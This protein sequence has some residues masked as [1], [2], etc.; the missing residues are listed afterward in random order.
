MMARLGKPITRFY[1][2][3]ISALISCLPQR[4]SSYVTDLGSNVELVIAHQGN[5]IFIQTTRGKILDSKSLTQDVEIDMAMLPAEKTDVRAGS[6]NTFIDANKEVLGTDPPLLQQDDNLDITLNGQN[7]EVDI[8][9]LDLSVSMEAEDGDRQ[10]CD[11]DLSG[12]SNS[13]NVIP[14]TINRD[15]NTVR[16]TE[17]EDPTSRLVDID[18]DNGDDTIIVHK[19]QGKLLQFGSTEA[20]APDHTVLFASVGGKIQQVGADDFDSE[21]DD[22]VSA[23]ITPAPAEQP[24]GSNAM[25]YGIVAKM[26]DQYQGNRKCLYIIPERDLFMVKLSYPLEVMENLDGVLRFDLEKHIP[27]SVDGVRYFYALN[28]DSLEN[29]VDVD[30]AVIKSNDFDRLNQVLGRFANRDLLCTTERFYRK[31]GNRINFLDASAA[32]TNYSFLRLSNIHQAFNYAL[33]LVLIALP[34]YLFHQGI[35]NIGT[36]SDSEMRR[37]RDIVTSINTINDESR[38]GS[39]LSAQIGK[40]PKIVSLLATLSDSI[41]DGA[42][43]DR[44]SYK[45]GEISIR[46]EADS[47]TA[48]SDELS[49]T[50]L[51]ENIKFVSSIRKNPKSGQETFELLMRLKPDA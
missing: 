25:A 30:I 20:Q 9:L 45:D 2:W 40:A 26:L 18:R 51:F 4:Y 49:R 42:W 8:N 47:A 24:G 28:V 13:Q 1:R 43:L 14:L 19:D 5:S 22:A 29:R 37:V 12:S 38:F 11:I 34:F 33:L 21:D 16:L 15:E 27:V 36:V 48:V 17:E 23:G 3:W 31:Y 39:Q 7:Q 6:Y 10:Q 41:N 50:G 35:T 44:Y 46:G 32:T